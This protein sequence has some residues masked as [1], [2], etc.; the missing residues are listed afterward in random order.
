MQ[1]PE[2]KERC[3]QA[4]VLPCTL[5][6]ES[7]DVGAVS[8]KP[9]VL[10]NAKLIL[11][12]N[13]FRDMLLRVQTEKFARQYTLQNVQTFKRFM[14]EGKA[15]LQLKDYSVRLMISNAPPN[16]L[17]I[18]LKT[19]L[20]KAEV[21][22]VKKVVGVRQRLL[23]SLPSAFE[24]ISPLTFQE[25]ESVRKA[26][27]RVPLQEKNLNIPGASPVSSKR[28]R[29][30]KDTP[31]KTK[32]PRFL[33][34]LVLSGEQKRVLQAIQAGNNV[35]FTGSAGTGKS[36]LLQ[37]I[38]G[39]LPP[40]TTFTT[41]STGIAACQIGGTTLHAFAGIGSGTAT[42]EQ[43][44]Q[45]AS[46]R[47]IAQQWRKCR[48]LIVDEIS[49]VDGAFF[50]KL[51]GVARAVRGNDKPFGGI[52]LILCGDFLQLP[53]VTK[54]GEKRIFCFQTLAWSRCISLNMELKQV[55]RQDDDE[56]INILQNIRIGKC[57][58]TMAKRL[59]GTE[60]NRV[61]QGKIKATRLCTHK[62]DVNHINNDHLKKLEGQERVFYAVDT[63]PTLVG[64]L[65][66]QTPVVSKLVLKVGAQVMLMKN[67]D[68]GC[69]LVNGARGVVTGFR[70]GQHG[71]PTV[72]FISGVQRDIKQEKWTIKGAGGI[73]LTRQQLPLKLAWA[74]S[75]HKSQG[76]TLDCAEMSLSRVFEAG[77]AYVALS[78]ARNLKS[79]RVLDFNPSAIR[80]HPDVLSF[81]KS[82]QQDRMLEQQNIEQFCLLR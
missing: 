44:I 60:G 13:E 62:E 50:E 54:P 22:S 20:G 82:L 74:F 23:S 36:F 12:R 48:H 30:G 26:K 66:K 69:G 73:Y 8:K 25:Y 28:K 42:L 24:E 7:L 15:T 47:V 80:A 21:D 29:E 61:E 18:F 40:D 70:N 58:E 27:G 5:T 6:V 4:P 14:K 17:L 64:L 71:T 35:F 56:F 38:V 67:L 81:Y 49:M 52:Q 55:R 79:I 33:N 3:L 75:I 46:R 45:L 11:G 39:A 63:D 34:P 57:T 78:R 43:C 1:T 19:L 37:R 32:V 72:Q 41:A 31:T 10:K 53:P 65:D 51:E 77:Q 76:M 16:L 59:K 68:V 2:Q 9:L